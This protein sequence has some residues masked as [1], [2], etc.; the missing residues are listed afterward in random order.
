MSPFRV[1]V[2]VCVFTFSIDFVFF[3]FIAF[4]RMTQRIKL[5]NRY[6]RIRPEA[7]IEDD[8]SNVGSSHTI[9]LV[10]KTRL[11]AMATKGSNTF[12]AAVVAR[13]VRAD[14]RREPFAV[15]R[16]TGRSSVAFDCVRDSVWHVWDAYSAC[17]CV[18]SRTRLSLEIL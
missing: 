10:A 18:C 1:R 9:G 8:D 7:P 12:G 14:R 6:I 15:R 5:E 3:I 17:D 13:A 2:R 11:R 4:P 16:T